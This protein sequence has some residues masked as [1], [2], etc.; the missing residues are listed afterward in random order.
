MFETQTSNRLMNEAA[1]WRRT[2]A[3]TKRRRYIFGYTLVFGNGL[4][5][6]TK[7]VERSYRFWHPASPKSLGNRVITTTILTILCYTIAYWFTQRSWRRG[8]RLTS[9]H[10]ATES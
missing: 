4:L 6:A 5:A 2:M 3:H 1:I 10:P 8:I 9:E 7:I